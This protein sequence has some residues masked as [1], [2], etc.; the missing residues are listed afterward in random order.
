[1]P[2]ELAVNNVARASTTQ[3]NACSDMGENAYEE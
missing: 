3:K 2:T 1:M